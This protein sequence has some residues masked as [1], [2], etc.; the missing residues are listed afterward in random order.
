MK[1]KINKLVNFEVFD[2]MTI[3]SFVYLLVFSFVQ[4]FFLFGLKEAFSTKILYTIETFIFY[5]FLVSVH[6]KLFKIFV[7]L[8]FLLT[9]FVFPSIVVSGGIT[10]GYVEACLYTDTQ[11]INS[12]FTLVPYW[13]LGVLLLVLLYSVFLLKQNYSF[14]FVVKKYRKIIT[15]LLLLLVLVNPVKK[16]IKYGFF[17]MENKHRY[18]NVILI[19]YFLNIDSNVRMAIGNHNFMQEVLKKECDWNIINRSNMKKTPRNIVV[20]M[21]ESVRK[22]FLHSYGFPIK[23]TSFIDSSANMQFNNYYSV[24]S[25]TVPSI[26]RTIA[27]S[28]D[29][30]EIHLNN[31]IFSLSKLLDYQ[32]FFISNQGAS[33]VFDSPVASLGKMADQYYFMNMRDFKS[34]KCNSDIN[35]LSYVDS[36]VKKNVATNKLIVVHMYGSHPSACVATCN[37]YDEFIVSK[38]VSCYNKSIRNLDLFLKH[39]YSTLVEA[40]ENFDMVYFSDHGLRIN[41]NNALVHSPNYKQSYEIPLIVWSSDISEQLKINAIRINSDFMHLFSEILGIE[42]SNIKKQYKFI[43]EQEVEDENTSKYIEKHNKLLDNSAEWL[44]DVN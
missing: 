40:N 42:T 20:V 17:E 35:M 1:N 9:L 18:S 5:L 24:A 2:K 44:F 27:F 22:D 7:V 4:C 36:I 33:G 43:S 28:E 14:S 16:V 38:D 29:S 41:E 19:R 25:N 10:M 12:Y 39:I 23:N 11:E 31:N 6:Q 8:S 21:G 32:T 15:L 13:I 34:V 30:K 37:E 3:M 26:L